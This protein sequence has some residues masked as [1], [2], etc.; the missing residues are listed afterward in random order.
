MGL[1][2]DACGESEGVQVEVDCY[3]GGVLC[4]EDK[5]G[6]VHACLVCW[7]CGHG[8]L[9]CMYAWEACGLLL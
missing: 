3:V 6:Q 4:A 2:V 7:V 5:R 9:E 1:L 8:L